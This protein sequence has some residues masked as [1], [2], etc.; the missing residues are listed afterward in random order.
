E[1]D[2]MTGPG[3]VFSVIQNV[4]NHV[5]MFNFH[6][7]YDTVTILNHSAKPVR[8]N[9]IAVANTTV[10]PQVEI[11]FQLLPFLFDVEHTFPPTVVTIANVGPVGTPGLT[12]NGFINNP[13]GNTHLENQQGNIVS[14]GPQAIVRTNI[15]E[16]L[17][18]HGDAGAV[19]TPINAELVQGP[20]R[21]PQV[22]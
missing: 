3:A 12:L 7:T 13:I 5:P 17:V 19:G 2:T 22:S 14:T 6:E 11:G 1:A 21:V 16:I 15:L 4:N 8:V 18:P 10:V 20:G 9:G